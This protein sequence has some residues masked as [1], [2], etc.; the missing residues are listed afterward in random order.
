VMGK[1]E[2]VVAYEVLER[3]GELSQEKYQVLALY[4]KGIAA[5]DVF[6][7]TTAQGFFEQALEIDPD[8]GPAALYADR[9]EDYA[10]NPPAD[11]VF[12][13]ESK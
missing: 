5:Y 6:D 2:P 11:L 7:F 13:A 9:C 1:E 10:E 8:D 3:K 12:R 4:E